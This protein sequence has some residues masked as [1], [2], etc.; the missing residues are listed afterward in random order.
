VA[1]VAGLV[2]L[3]RFMGWVDFPDV[4]DV[5]AFTPVDTLVLWGRDN[6]S[7]ITRPINDFIC[8]GG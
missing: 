7:F 2:V 3:G 6:L 8:A 4:W 5:R 1:G